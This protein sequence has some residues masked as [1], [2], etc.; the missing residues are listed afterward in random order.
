MDHARLLNVLK[1]EN[2]LL[3][4]RVLHLE[5]ILM[6]TNPLPLEW[7]LT[8]SESRVFGVLVN[9]DLATKDAVMAALYS[10]RLDADADVE[11]KIVDVL[12]CK[13]RKKVARFG[14]EVRTVWGQG[15]SI[16]PDIRNRYRVS[17]ERRAA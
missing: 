12:I 3:R 14:I 6:Q 13:I 17:N 10:D 11:P 1:R 9:R 2:E 7:R 8:P 15:W 4:E 5:N 16:D